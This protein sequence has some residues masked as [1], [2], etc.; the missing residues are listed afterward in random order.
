ML[1]AHSR[2]CQ[3]GPDLALVI[4]PRLCRE[5]GPPKDKARHGLGGACPK[6]TEGVQSLRR[7]TRI[8]QW[9]RTVATGQSVAPGFEGRWGGR[10]ARRC[11]EGMEMMSSWTFAVTSPRCYLQV[12]DGEAGEGR[13]P[14][15]IT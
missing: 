5:A 6:L 11:G 9:L 10:E 1:T 12:P 13:G 3:P 2:L 14:A 15:P 7:L 4:L 8:A